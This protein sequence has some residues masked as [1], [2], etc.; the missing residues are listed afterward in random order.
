MNFEHKYLSSISIII[1]TYNRVNM[2][3]ELLSQINTQARHFTSTIEIIIV[4]DNSPVPIV[5]EHNLDNVNIIL[6]RNEINVGANRS[7]KIGFQHSTGEI[8]H[9][10]DSDDLIGPSWLSMI[11]N[12][13]HAD[14]E[15]DLLVTSRIEH[16]LQKQK[17]KLITT[18]RLSKIVC[19]VDRLRKVQYIINRLGP[20]GGVTFRR[21][22]VEKFQFHN[23][24][25]S[26][27]WLMYDDALA[28]TQNVLLDPSN[29][30]IFNK[31]NSDRISKKPMNRLRGYVSVARKR[32][33]S[34][35]TQ[36]FMARI[37]CVQGARDL[38]GFVNIKYYFVKVITLKC[39]IWVMSR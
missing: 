29:Y 12:K 24:R 13:F 14:D 25:A 11:F 39:T 6:I 3:R 8:I 4:D 9:F 7:R 31:R 38:A 19:N 1:P 32:F 36:K 17:S 21:R 16:D 20:L 28:L 34:K 23:V 22:I 26:Q 18:N 35:A 5:L 37:Y 30:F 15:L 2:L 33:N 10:H 27:D